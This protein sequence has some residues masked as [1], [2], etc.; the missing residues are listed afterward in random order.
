M[1]AKTGWKPALP[2]SYL[3]RSVWACLALLAFFEVETSAQEPKVRASLA[4]K[5]DVWLGQRV[6]VVVELLAPGYFTGAAAFDLPDPQGV[7]LVPPADHPTVA[8][9]EIDGVSYTVQRHELSAF[10]RR[11][12]KT[13]IP[14]LTARFSFKRQ[15]LDK[16]VVP[17]TVKT[18]ALK[19]TAKVPP[20]A[21]KLGSIIS[22]RNLT[23]VETWKPE[24]GPAKAG[25][26]FVRT[27]TYA[28][29]EV[30][31]MAFPPFPAPKI[32]GL[33]IYRKE[34]EVLD[35][36]ERGSLRGE[37]RD[38]IT[39]VCQR[40]G[41]F[42]IPATRLTWFDLDAKQ[43]QTI[44]F[45]ARTLTVAPNPATATPGPS[46]MPENDGRAAAMFGLVAAIGVS[47]FSVALWKTRGFWRLSDRAREALRPVHLAPLNPGGHDK[48]RL[49]PG[50]GSPNPAPTLR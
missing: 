34:P 17:A 18:E 31:A 43:L 32:D 36:S 35:Q 14:P 46:A 44:D 28:A 9:E 29:P 49:D 23:A 33:G 13:T 10:A 25:D 1:P 26:A 40:P 45:P 42:T 47:L 30:P 4:E 20:G 7:L 2:F 21:E 27:I 50:P 39:Y 19:F 41:Q 15:P 6:T 38:A 3:L 11:A 48:A 22:A 12:G 8:S 24:P 5:G 16:E 37:R